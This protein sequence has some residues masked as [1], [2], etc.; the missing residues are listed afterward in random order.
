MSIRII[1]FDTETTGLNPQVDQIVEICFKLGLEINGPSKTYLVRPTTVTAWPEAEAVH[2]ISPKQVSPAFT[3]KH[4]APAFKQLLES[5]DVLVGYNIQFDIDM[6]QEEFSRAG[7]GQ[8]SLEGTVV[9]DPLKIWRVS[10]PKKLVD[11]YRRF[12][13]GGFSEDDAHSAREDVQ[14][15]TDVLQGMMRDFDLEGM[16]WSEIATMCDPDRQ[17]WVGPTHHFIW[18]EGSIN[19]NFGKHK[20]CPVTSKEGKSYAKWMSTKVFPAHVLRIC[21]L[22]QDRTNEELVQEISVDSKG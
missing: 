15:T 3:F 6:V 17:H 10:E 4:M 21:Q 22:C 16:S 9:I 5:A 7:M 18:K 20:G 12:V 19:L 2:G 11:A 14:A 8:F 1:T 13:G